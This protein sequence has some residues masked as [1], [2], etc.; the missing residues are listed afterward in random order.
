MYSRRELKAIFLK[1]T[2]YGIK[3]KPEDVL[4]GFRSCVK[5]ENKDIIS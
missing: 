5:S 4:S 3:R 2:L 1:Y